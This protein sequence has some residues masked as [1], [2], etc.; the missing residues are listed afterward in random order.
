MKVLITGGTGFLGRYVALELLARGHEVWLLGREFAPVRDLLTSGAHA[1]AADLRDANAILAACAGMDAVVHAGAKSEPWG[2]R[3][4]FFAINAE[5]TRAIVAGCRAHHVDRLV[6]ISSPAVV[7]DG[8]DQREATEKVPYP[9]RFTSVYAQ[10]KK[11]G[12]DAINAEKN[13]LATV[14]L[15]PKAI[16]GPG[17]RALLP[18]LITAA[19]RGRLPQIGDGRNHVD[20]TFVENIALATALALESSTA[21]GKTFTITNDEHPLLWELIRDALR[22]QRLST[23]LRQIP[24]SAALVAASAM[25]AIAAIR[26]REPLL[27]RYSALILAREQTYDITAAKRDLGYLPRVSIAD[28]ITRTLD[29]L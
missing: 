26:G 17:D 13:D 19:Q 4:D 25:E 28:G 27:T 8:S 23:H 15:R 1:V 3:A 12:E 22:H 6:Y 14:I 7:F 2:N 20:L 24:L 5:G 16:F 21:I 18:R 9:Q 10:T 11:L 29:A